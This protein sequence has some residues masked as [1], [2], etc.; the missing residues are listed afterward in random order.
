MSKGSAKLIF[1][2]QLCNAPID[3]NIC[4]VHGIDFVTIKKIYD[5]GPRRQTP[6]PGTNGAASVNTA[7]HGNS[8]PET[9]LARPEG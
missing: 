1:F 8:S 2:C 4:K 6:Q 7:T 5:D 9:R 3:S